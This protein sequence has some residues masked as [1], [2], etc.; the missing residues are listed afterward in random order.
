LCR[1][2][3]DFARRNQVLAVAAGVAVVALVWLTGTAMLRVMP[4]SPRQSPILAALT[5]SAGLEETFKLLALL[6]LWR[7]SRLRPARDLL[8]AATGIACGFAAAENVL[9]LW[10]AAD[11]AIMLFQRIAIAL[12]LHLACAAIMT[13][14]I[15][16]RGPCTAM[17][18]LPAL[19]AAIVAHAAYDAAS[20]ADLQTMPFVIAAVLFV[21][22][23]HAWWRYLRRTHVA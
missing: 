12:P 10:S 11:P 22:T 1:V 2:L 18:L 8:P 23:C 16:R 15:T 4:L 13:S 9:V 7:V 17:R 20:F 3:T 6:L 21:F 5:Y 14:I 19:L